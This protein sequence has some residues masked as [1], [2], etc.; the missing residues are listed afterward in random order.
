MEMSGAASALSAARTA[1][2]IAYA[3]QAVSFFAG[4]LPLLVAL[5][6]GYLKR[7]EVQGV[8]L[9]SHFTWQ[10]RTFWYSL[11]W[12]VLGAATA[13]ILVGYLILG[14]GF[15]WFLYRVTLYTTKITQSCNI[16]LNQ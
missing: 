2:Q 14:L 13:I 12:I 1:A 9:E 8:W 3:L 6:I 5:I 4:G 11:L 15:L 16:V 7:S 10:I